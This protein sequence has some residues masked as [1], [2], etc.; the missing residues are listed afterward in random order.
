MTSVRQA[1]H[2]HNIQKW[3]QIIMEQRASGL[4]GMV[5]CRQAEINCKT[6][7]YWLL[8]ECHPKGASGK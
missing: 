3:T 4:S 6:F 2:Q 1:K 5:Y 8:A 7:Y